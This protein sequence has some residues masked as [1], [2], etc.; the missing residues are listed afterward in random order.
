MREL[1]LHILDLLMNSIEANASR[2]ILCI[3]ESE[4][5]NRLQ[6]IVR[7]NGKGMSAEMIELALDPFVTSRKTRS[8]GMGL[9][10]LRQVASQC[11]GDV[12]L[13]SAIGKG[14]QV[15]VTM[16]LNHINRMPLGNCAVTLV[17]TMIGNLDV[18]FYYLHKTDSGLFPFDSFWLL[19]EMDRRGCQAHELVDEAT[20][21]IR[22]GLQKIKSQA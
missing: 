9:A 13:T 11:G 1:S 10:L 15:S 21:I 12:E 19:A 14:T 5:E 16:E 4:K 18:H 8:V 3:R 7:D 6:F 17:N 22:N 2:V 20:E